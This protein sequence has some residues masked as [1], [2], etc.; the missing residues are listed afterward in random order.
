MAELYF[1]QGFYSQ[2]VEVYQEVLKR[3]PDNERARSRLAEIEPLARGQDAPPSPDA[4]AL[5]RQAL[6]RTISRLEQLLATVQR[7]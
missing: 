7:G 5:R 2:A 6:E 1:E 4:H 3:E